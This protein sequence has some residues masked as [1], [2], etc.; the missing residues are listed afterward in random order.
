[1]VHGT[2]RTQHAYRDAFAE[3]GRYNNFVVLAPLFPVGPLGD[4]EADGYKYI[5]EGDIRY[6]LVL[7]AMVAEVEAMLGCRFPPFLMF[8]FSGGGHFTHRFM[9]LH[10][11]RLH[12]ASIGAPGSLTLLDRDRDW[13]VGVRNIRSLFGRDLD[14]A[15]LARVRVHLV[16]GEAD[17]ET[18]EIR[19]EPG[20]PRYME[21]ANDAGATRVERNNSLR[22]SLEAHGVAVTQNI[23]PGVAH[24]MTGVLPYTI[25]FF[26]GVLRTAPHRAVA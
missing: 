8:G 22:A 10:P 23:V 26:R 13:W 5:L 18:W 11:E 25:D 3:F 17:L 7:L 2:G 6:D 16:V 12:A 20:D 14:L 9:I 15:A 4:G 1:V 19:H 24:S 21:G